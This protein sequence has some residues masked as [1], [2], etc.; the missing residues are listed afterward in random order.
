MQNSAWKNVEMRI[1]TVDKFLENT[2][3]VSVIA[4]TKTF[5]NENLDKML[6]STRKFSFKYEIIIVLSKPQN[7]TDIKHYLFDRVKSLPNLVKGRI[8]LM[9]YDKGPAPCR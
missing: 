3:Y 7:A 4:S 5:P 1:I 8:I 9:A 6:E 2:A